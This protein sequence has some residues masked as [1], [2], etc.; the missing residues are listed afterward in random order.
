[1]LSATLFDS[2]DC[3]LH[4]EILCVHFKYIS[5]IYLTIDHAIPLITVYLQLLL[6]FGIDLISCETSMDEK[7]MILVRIVKAEAMT[8]GEVL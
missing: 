3:V 6:A 2:F 1:M 5:I 4:I 8:Q 7:R